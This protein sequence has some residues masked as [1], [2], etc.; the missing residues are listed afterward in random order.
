M[1][2]YI[3]EYIYIYIYVYI[4]IYIYIYTLAKCFSTSAD[5]GKVTLLRGCGPLKSTRRHGPF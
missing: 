4:Y 5:S 3:Y 1:N 2:I